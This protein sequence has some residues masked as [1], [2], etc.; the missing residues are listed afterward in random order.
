MF[1]QDHDGID[2]ERMFAPTGAERR[3][4][5]VDVIDK[6]GRTPVKGMSV[7]QAEIWAANLTVTG[8]ERK[9]RELEI[10]I[11]ELNDTV[12]GWGAI[13]GGQL[14]GLYTAPEF[15]GRGIGTEL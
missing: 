8:M 13:R 4:Q 10:W 5:R 2:R 12:V 1:W 6:R 15:V 7:A 9:I 3:P 11:V 14:E